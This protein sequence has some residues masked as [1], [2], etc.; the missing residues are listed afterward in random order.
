[1]RIEPV[2]KARVFESIVDQIQRQILAG[3]MKAGDRLPNERDLAVQFGVSRASVREAL[4]ALQLMGLIESKVGG[5]TYAKRDVLEATI[6]PI[7]RALATE[8]D[9]AEEPLEVRKILEPQIAWL[10]AERATPEDIAEI[11]SRL[12]DQQVRVA[13]GQPTME[14]DEAFHLAIARATK[15]RVLERLVVMINDLIKPSRLDPPRTS[16]DAIRTLLGHKSILEAIRRGDEKAA[17]DAMCSHLKTVQH[18]ITTHIA[19]EAGVVAPP[20]PD[21]LSTRG[22]RPRPRTK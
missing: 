8:I 1:M 20:L 11:E 16:Q 2:R 18:I 9:Q 6:T 17:Y 5:G 22:A 14:E 3:E 10:A 15:N 12:E 19:E 7:A 13:A 21:H 4:A